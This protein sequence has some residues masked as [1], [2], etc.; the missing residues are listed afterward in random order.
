MTRRDRTRRRTM[1]TAHTRATDNRLAASTGIRAD[2]RRKL[3]REQ[4]RAGRP[5]TVKANP[6]VPVAVEPVPS[7]YK[8]PKPRRRAYRGSDNPLAQRQPLTANRLVLS[9]QTGM[10]GGATS[11][12]RVSRLWVSA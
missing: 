9:D 7:K 3:L 5:V 1:A 6:S 12:R 11:R 8:A 2:D 10:R 4:R